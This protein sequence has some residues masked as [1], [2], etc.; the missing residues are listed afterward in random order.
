[1]EIIRLSSYAAN[2]LNNASEGTIH[3]VY[4][5]TVNLSLDGQIL[6]LQSK[7]SPF[8][9]VSLLTDTEAPELGIPG[10]RP[11]SPFRICS[12]QIIIGPAVI[13]FSSAVPEDLYLP[14]AALS[15]VSAPEHVWESPLPDRIR[16]VLRSV[17]PDGFPGI[18]Q[19]SPEISGDLVRMAAAARMH[20]A[21][22]AV[23]AG[24]AALAAKELSSLIG[25]GTGL[26]PSGDDF[27]C[28]ILAG[29]RLFG[30]SSSEN[31]SGQA[32]EY[33]AEN[34]AFSGICPAEILAP[35][36]SAELHR[37]IPEMLDRTNKISRSFLLCALDGQFSE[38]VLLLAGNPSADTI[39]EMF[40]AIGHSSGLDTLC[41]IW[42]SFS[43]S[44]KLTGHT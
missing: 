19:D 13:S 30:T 7:G 39:R 23:H 43:S 17:S 14:T 21:S 40:G 25:I 24:D 31:T 32:F 12:Q 6:A 33:P 34:D 22:D 29:L 38:A 20:A 9:P 4:R 27:L 42:F 28:G 5:R 1:M 11:G 16:T 44:L 10:L 8:S 37:R 36:L 2:I 15:A 3:S 35:G 18:L 41:G 26:T